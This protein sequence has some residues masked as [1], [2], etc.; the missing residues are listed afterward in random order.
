MNGTPSFGTT[1]PTGFHI[2]ILS[3]QEERRISNP[4]IY[5]A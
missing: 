5:L 4:S 1:R 3:I 2:E